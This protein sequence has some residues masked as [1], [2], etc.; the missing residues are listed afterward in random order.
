MKTIKTKSSIFGM[1]LLAVVMLCAVGCTKNN[2]LGSGLQGWYTDLSKPAKQSDFNEIN[3]AINNHELLMSYSYSNNYYATYDLFIDDDYGNFYCSAAYFGRLRNSVN[4]IIW[5]IQI[6]DNS[7]L[8]IYSGVLYPEGG[9][10]TSGK[11]SFYRLYAGSIFGNM[12]Y[13]ASPVNYTYVKSDNKIVVTNGDIYTITDDGLIKDGSSSVLSK[14]D[15][16]KLYSSGSGGG[17]SGGGNSGGGNNGG[18][19]SGGGTNV[20]G[21]YNGHDYVD[22]GLPSGTKWATCNVGAATPEDYGDYFA[23]AETTTKTSY[24]WNNYQYCN[25]ISYELTKYCNNSSYGLDGFT[26]NLT[27]LQSSDD[28]ATANWGGNWRMPTKTEWEEL[29]QKTT[30]TWTSQNGVEGRLFTA[31]NGNMLFLPAAGKYVFDSNYS[32]AQEGYYWSGMLNTDNPTLAWFFFLNEYNCAMSSYDQHPRQHGRSVRA[33][34]SS[35]KQ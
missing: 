25:H 28:A 20:S 33:V 5:A 6:V 11:E 12:A 9:T 1:V 4:C 16:T 13:Y 31:N 34:C 32:I 15:P 14:Y 8:K 27:K 24:E 21:S 3:T 18:G 23:W 7:T 26:D 2:G 22:L 30:S 10:G 35:S 17:N 19:G 29:Y